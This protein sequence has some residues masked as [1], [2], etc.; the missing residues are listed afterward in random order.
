[1][2]AGNLTS[3]FQRRGILNGKGVAKV[4][5]QIYP[6]PPTNCP[7]CHGEREW[8]GVVNVAVCHFCGRQEKVK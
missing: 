1:M 3:L 2:T 4:G 7:W 8:S 6:S 5:K